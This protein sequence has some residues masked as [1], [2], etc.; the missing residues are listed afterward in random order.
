[1]SEELI[2]NVS[3]NN[4]MLEDYFR[5]IGENSQAYAWMYTDA[6]AI[7]ARRRTWIDIPSNI[8]A[9]VTGFLSVGSATMFE[10][11]TRMSSIGLGIASLLVSIMN[12]TKSYFS[13]SQKAE[14]C[15]ISAYHYGKLQRLIV[16][17]M[18]LPV[19][20]RIR[21]GDF[22]KQVRDAFED[23]SKTSYPIPPESIDA[24]KKRFNDQKYNGFHK[25]TIVNGLEKIEVYKEDALTIRVPPPSAL[26]SPQPAGKLG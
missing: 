5:K 12:M 8:L 2:E 1:M 19:N 11:E 22:L 20:E 21:C 23:L 6:E 3:W 7:Y 24:F 26:P 17:Q 9:T 15:K 18:G 14:G 4:P 10:G 16:L 25:P 13:W